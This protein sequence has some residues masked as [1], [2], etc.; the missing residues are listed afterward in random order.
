VTQ[1]FAELFSAI[2][3]YLK[4]LQGRKDFLREEVQVIRITVCGAH[5][6]TCFLFVCLFFPHNE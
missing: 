5:S 1:D 2:K 3:G 6:E 4:V